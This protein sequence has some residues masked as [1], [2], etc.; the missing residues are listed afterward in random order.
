MGAHGRETEADE[1]LLV[2]V[3][4]GTRRAVATLPLS[5]RVRNADVSPDG[6]TI[7]AA[8]VES[9][10]DVWAVKN[11]DTGLPSTRPTD[12]WLPARGAGTLER[13]R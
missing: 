8:V 5:V 12:E 3:E 11:F 4:S 13:R 9:H 1:L 6:R 7:V 10:S 2:E